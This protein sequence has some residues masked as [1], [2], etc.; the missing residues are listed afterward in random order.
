MLALAC[1][2]VACGGSN[3]APTTMGDDDGPLPDGTP[4]EPDTTPVVD[5]DGDGLDDALELELANAYLPYISL[6]PDD[7]CTRD[8][9]V[10]RVRPHPA[11]PTKI[12]IFYDHL[13]ETDC[14]LN[15]HTGD[16]E[17]FGITID[18]DI[19]PPAGILA[20]KTASH[21]NTPCERVT[22][23]T[24]CGGGNACDMAA[25]NGVMYPVLYAS[26]DKHGQYATKSACGFGTCFDSC[27]LNPTAAH[28]AIVNAGEPGHP[29]VS[30][31]TTQGFITAANGWTK[32]ELMNVDPWASGDFGGA[33][34]IADD[35]VDPTFEAGT[36]N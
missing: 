18:P 17:M 2:L 9:L 5:H 1:L 31:L 34:A 22:E 7:G 6:A 36:C 19:P 26:K 11:D 35:L 8:G 10:V 29:L 14:G 27:T 12:S 24:T 4:V 33:G 30:N 15:G 21:Q 16:D 28:P 13:F 23:C 32:P 3:R 20:I 25:I